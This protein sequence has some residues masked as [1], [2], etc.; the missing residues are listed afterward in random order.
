MRLTRDQVRDVDHRAIHE[1]AIPGVVLMENAA[2][3]CVRV[4]SEMLPDI[5]GKPVLILCGG[6]NNGGDGFAI[7]R[8]LSIAQA[9]VTIG[10]M[11]DP[12]VSRDEALSN[13]RIVKAM[14][15]PS[16]QATPE[17]IAKNKWS[18]IV[19]AL[20]GTGLSRPPRDPFPAMASAV[21]ASGSPV[22]AVDVPSGLDCDTGKPLGAC[23]NAT[24]T[25]T[26]VAAKVGFDAPEA[27]TY[28]GELTVAGIGCPVELDKR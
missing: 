12:E 2:I 7:A 23:I 26:F 9:K 10:L 19:D 16:Q 24:R 18:L 5:A 17:L 22:L 20:F 14:K 25:V 21:N 11:G 4:I 3:A 13:W 27:A 1:Y 28:L 8:H 15:I 6:G